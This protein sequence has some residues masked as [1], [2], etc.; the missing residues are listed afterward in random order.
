MGIGDGVHLAQTRDTSCRQYWWGGSFNAEISE[1]NYHTKRVEDV[2]DK[3]H[4]GKI[5]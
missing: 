2:K 5:T 4:K 1:W 3:E